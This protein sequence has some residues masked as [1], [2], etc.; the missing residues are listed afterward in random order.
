MNEGS[1]AYSL[2]MLVIFFAIMYFFLIRPQQKQ[3][4]QRRTMLDSLRVGDKIVSIGGI[5]G[6]IRKI[7][8]DTIILQIA[9]KVEIELAKN[10]VS[11]IEN[12]NYLE[13]NEKESKKSKKE[14]EASNENDTEESAE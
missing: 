8:E 11:S 13:D 2:V 5:H 10:G 3:A 12:R 7:K 4:K 6:K 1:S 14:K 9:D